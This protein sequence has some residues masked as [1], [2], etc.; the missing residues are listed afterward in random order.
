MIE[1][2]RRKELGI[3]AVPGIHLHGIDALTHIKSE[4]A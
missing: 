3:S 2:E 1:G 4:S